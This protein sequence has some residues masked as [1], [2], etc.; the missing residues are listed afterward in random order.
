MP[1]TQDPLFGRVEGERHRR[2]LNLSCVHFLSRNALGIL[3]SLK[4]KVDAA[5]GR[6]RPGGLEPDLHELPRITVLDHIFETYESG[7]DAL[8]A[9]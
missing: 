3:V 8:L 1:E 9:F 4:K 5:V 7:E 6:W 2:L